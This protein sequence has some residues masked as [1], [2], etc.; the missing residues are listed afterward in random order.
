[1]VSNDLYASFS[2]QQFAE[3][4]LHEH[5]GVFTKK[6]EADYALVILIASVSCEGGF[7]TQ[8]RT[9]TKFRNSLNNTFLTI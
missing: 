4:V 9:K 2:S 3:A 7:S 8:N 5:D 1:M 6:G